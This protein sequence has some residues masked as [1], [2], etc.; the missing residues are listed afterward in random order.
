MNLQNLPDFSL[1]TDD[2][3]LK[4][5]DLP[6]QTTSTFET[7]GW[8]ARKIDNPVVANPDA[9]LTALQREQESART[10]LEKR[11]K[12]MYAREAARLAKE[13]SA[14]F[15]TERDELNLSVLSEIE[16]AVVQLGS[17]TAFPLS[18]VSF[19]AGF[20]D[21]NPSE[22]EEVIRRTDENWVEIKHREALAKYRKEIKAANKQFDEAL[23]EI[24]Q[25][26]DQ[27]KM[28][29]L[30]ELTR[31]FQIFKDELDKRASREAQQQVQNT[32]MELGIQLADAA[33]WELPELKPKRE[34]L[35]FV[36][37]KLPGEVPLTS[38]PRGPSLASDLQL[39]LKVRRY[40]LAKKGAGR[41]ATKEFLEWRKEVDR[42]R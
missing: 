6:G 8:E 12:A 29:R 31:Q 41:D 16:D 24:K 9:T 40:E 20:P 19:I 17:R 35:Q 4:A 33:T 36:P 2:R 21:P 42:G 10:Q 38:I 26:L 7:K 3:A 5:P 25:K 13:L 11:L 39:F 1:A 37:A 32:L 22:T 27:K 23:A 15:R 28:A 14:K 30:A 34:T 18:R